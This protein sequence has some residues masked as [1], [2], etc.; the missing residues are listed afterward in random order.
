MR[1][2][3]SVDSVSHAL[4]DVKEY[5]SRANEINTDTLQMKL[6]HLDEMGRKFDH[7]DKELFSLVLQRFL[8]NKTQ[9]RIGHL[10]TSLLC[11]P[12]EAK[13]YDKEQKFLKLHGNNV[14]DTENQNNDNMQVT[15][16]SK[17]P[18]DQFAM[19]LQFMSNF[20]PPFP[21]MRFQRPPRPNF[22]PQRRGINNAR[23]RPGQN[24]SGCHICGDL[25]H[26]QIDC[27]RK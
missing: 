13:V 15:N 3:L 2:S 11:S 21:L 22:P 14:V 20:V 19:M 5:S 17:Q 6:M 8:C 9:P 27:P 26:F 12:A 7:P 16:G 10:V 25:S 24:Y 18:L 1:K 23:N 4:R